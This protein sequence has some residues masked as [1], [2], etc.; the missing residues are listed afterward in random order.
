[1]VSQMSW[2]GQRMENGGRGPG[3]NAIQKQEQTKEVSFVC[4]LNIW[5]QKRKPRLP[6][7][8]VHLSSWVRSA[9]EDAFPG[10]EIYCRSVCF[11]TTP[12]SPINRKPKAISSFTIQ[13]ERVISLQVLSKLAQSQALL[14]MAP[15]PIYDVYLAY[16]H[17]ENNYHVCKA[18]LLIDSVVSEHT[19]TLYRLNGPI[20][21]DM[22]LVIKK[23]FNSIK[24]RHYRAK[25]KVFPMPQSFLEKFESIVNET[26]R[27][28]QSD[29]LPQNDPVPRPCND[30]EWVQEISDKTR[31]QLSQAGFD[32][33][34]G[35]WW[36]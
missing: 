25:T 11:G 22:D 21:L 19:G 5:S 32:N 34:Y 12:F 9:L 13:P 15:T 30:S 28:L 26:L 27:P 35:P 18:L 6:C 31:S 1:M 20:S 24:S 16:F 3:S 29:I 23:Q 4:L 17:R 8:F 7:V 14:E 10:S 33:G 2:N 36:E